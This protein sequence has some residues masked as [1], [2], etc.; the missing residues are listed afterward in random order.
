M[1]TQL[2]QMKGTQGGYFN[3]RK[4]PEATSSGEKQLYRST[5]PT[6]PQSNT[7]GV[8]SS[9]VM[10]KSPRD[11]DNRSTTPTP[12][13]S[14]RGT[15]NAMNIR[16]S[17]RDSS[18]GTVSTNSN[19]IS[20]SGKKGVVDS[21]QKGAQRPGANPAVAPKA[22][23]KDTIEELKKKRERIKE[24]A[25]KNEKVIFIPKETKVKN[26]IRRE[27]E[28]DPDES[29]EGRKE[30]TLF[31][32]EEHYLDIADDKELKLRMN[33]NQ[34][35]HEDVKIIEVQSDQPKK[36]SDKKESLE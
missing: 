34:K 33:N 18:N 10:V 35:A 17:P 31:I 7:P 14:L 16:G 29:R 11:K 8:S 22:F 3:S 21:P 12:S 27:E 13:A 36:N 1:Y 19:I 20:P 30:E 32:G 28:L 25:K 2:Q 15:P 9:V 23:N 26:T 4:S 6:P 5:T 24:E